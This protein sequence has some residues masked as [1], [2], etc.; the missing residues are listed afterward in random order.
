MCRL[1]Q[2][3]DVSGVR[4]GRE[5]GMGKVSWKAEN[6][7]GSTKQRRKGNEETQQRAVTVIAVSDRLTH[8]AKVDEA[9]AG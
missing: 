4:E 2:S 6:M 5:R 7:R 9:N 1:Y 8:H 3:P